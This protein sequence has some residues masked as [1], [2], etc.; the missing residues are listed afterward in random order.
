[1]NKFAH[2]PNKIK[3]P[4]A[5]CVYC[6]K[7]YKLRNNL[8]KHILLC[9][10]I[11]KSNNNK[12][13]SNTIPKPLEE[14]ENEIELPS[15]RKM[16]QLL[17]E[18]SKKYSR[19]EEKVEQLTKAMPTKK[20]VLNGLEWLNANVTPDIVFDNM[21]DKITILD[22]DVEFLLKNTYNDTLNVIFSRTIY[23]TTTQN[24]TTQNQNQNQ[25]QNPIFAFAQKA[26]LFYM[27]D[28]IDDNNNK[29]W[30][31]LSKVKL[32]RFLNIVQM[33]ISKVFSEWRK[34]N[35]DEIYSNDKFAIMC[36]KSV[37][38]LM[39][40]DFNHEGTLNKIRSMMYTK[41]KTTFPLPL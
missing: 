6:G 5:C 7:G 30:T 15:Q 13:K 41:M 40:P 23:P 22:S 9:E 17:V 16:F 38:K 35:K 34:T 21:V 2:I 4:A 28:K 37:I 10:L 25:N 39:D 1:M 36:D 26:N 24:L 19:L 20:P 33:K 29:G 8:D 3:Q 14:D 31:E 11:Y 18:L 12:T 27:Y 32:V